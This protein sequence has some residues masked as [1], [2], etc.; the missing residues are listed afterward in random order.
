MNELYTLLLFVALLSVIFSYFYRRKRQRNSGKTA[1][2][3]LIVADNLLQQELKKSLGDDYQ[4][5]IFSDEQEGFASLKNEPPCLM[6]IDAPTDDHADELT[7]RVKDNIET[8]HIPVIQ[9]ISRTDKELAFRKGADDFLEK[10]IKPQ[11]LK[12]MV[13][14]QLTTREQVRSRYARLDINSDVCINCS[15]DLDWK[16]IASVKRLVE[17]NM[18]KN[19]FNVDTLCALLNMSR[20]SFYNKIKALTDQP[21]A[22]YV[23]LIKLKK[24]AQL[25]KEGELNINE[26]AGTTGFSDAKYFREVFKKHYKVSPSKYKKNQSE[27]TDPDS[28]RGL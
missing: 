9:L 13:A 21:P 25:L 19:S 8:S 2:L 11:L 5:T 3:L 14:N 10:P 18:N 26:I 12:T 22:D 16:F 4:L 17:E 1:K 23:R 15:S 20:T 6:I 28:S 7:K 27:S 24:A